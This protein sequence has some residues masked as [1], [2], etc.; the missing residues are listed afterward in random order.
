M[1]R[2]PITQEGYDKLREEIRHLESDVMPEIAE[3]I[4]DARAEGDLK[5]NTEYHAQR[6]AQGMT[7]AKINQLKSKL[8]NCY[9][10][11]KSTMPKGV[12][13]F[14]SIVTVKNLDDG[15]DEKYEFVGPGEEDYLGEV[16]KI[17]TSSPLAEGLLNKKVGDKVEVEV[18]S[19]TLK[20]E[21][22]QIED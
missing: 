2:H 10:A 22:I 6:E 3:K 8:A 4:A 5:E 13:T 19:G 17:L 16:M 21:V 14:G 18:P 15:L 1:D 20:F 7:Q 9:I 11:D 12:V